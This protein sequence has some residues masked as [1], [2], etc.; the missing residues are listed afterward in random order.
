MILAYVEGDSFSAL[1]Q[2]KD[3]SLIL[4]PAGLAFYILAELFKQSQANQKDSELTI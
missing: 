2:I 3:D 1:R 4:I